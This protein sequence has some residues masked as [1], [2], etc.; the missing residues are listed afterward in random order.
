[1]IM[2]T[3]F[4]GIGIIIFSMGKLSLTFS[5]ILPVNFYVKCNVKDYHM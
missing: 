1:M 5:D 3:Y 4:I 2:R